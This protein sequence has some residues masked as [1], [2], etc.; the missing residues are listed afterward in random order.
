MSEWW[1]YSVSD[2]L[3]FSPRTYYRLFELYNRAVW[4]AHILAVALGVLIIAFLRS[5]AAWSG[6]AV[7]IILTA[8][9]FGVA[10]AY[11][12]EH[13]STINWAASYVAAGFV[14]QALL[15]LFAGVAKVLRFPTRTGLPGISGFA[16]LL[17]ALL[18]QPF[19][20]CML[21]RPWTQSEV[22]GIAPDPTAIA[23]LGIIIGSDLRLAWWLLPIPLAWC[24]ISAAT[25]LSMGSPD[26]LVPLGT[27]C[28]CLCLVLI[29]RGQF[30]K[31]HK[32]R[33]R[34]SLES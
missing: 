7:S 16:M 27:A 19:I 15:I 23:T 20:G 17:F 2:F 6:Q 18:V 14:L 30:R 22:F 12:L 33:G 4:P 3:L 24:A 21:G 13:Y 29:G 1:T 10:W 9:W 11:F 32:P 28:L 34:S 8:C 26:A 25:L 31:A 5:K